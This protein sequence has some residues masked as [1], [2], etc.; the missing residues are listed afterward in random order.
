VQDAQVPEP[1]LGLRGAHGGPVVRHE[2]PR[3]LPL[4]E[5]LREPVD[6]GLGGLREVPLEVGDEPGAIIEDAQEVGRDPRPLG[7]QHLP[8]PRM[9]VGVPECVHVRDLEGADLDRRALLLGA[10]APRG[11]RGHRAART[12]QPLGAEEAADRG[13]RREGAER[14]GRRDHG[15]QVVDV[16]LHRPPRVRLPLGAEGLP[17]CQAETRLGAGVLPHAV[18]QRFDRI[19]AGVPRGVVP[20]FERRAG[21]PE[22]LAGRRVPP[23]LG[24]EAVERGAEV[25]RRGRR[26]EQRPHDREAQ[27][28]PVDPRCWCGH[29][30]SP[31]ACRPAA[32]VGCTM[33]ETVAQIPIRALPASSAG[34]SRPAASLHPTP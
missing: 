20:A 5:G 32:L 7:G 26:G 29:G 12:D 4:L 17:E 23:A 33:G 22:R 13:V 15:L 10:E 9:V 14:G 11:G 31:P 34:V 19:L 16:Q 8:A 3:Q 28:G 24:G 1:P 6:E 30:S 21:D 18:P 2:R 27:P 25:P